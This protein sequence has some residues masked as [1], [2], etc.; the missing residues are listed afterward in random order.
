L[1]RRS[2]RPGELQTPW[3]FDEI[4][5]RIDRLEMTQCR[6]DELGGPKPMASDQKKEQK[7]PTHIIKPG[8]VPKKTA[9]KSQVKT[10]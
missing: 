9:Q 10:D 8:G 4:K 7:E 6:K 5:A 2:G 1:I 3:I